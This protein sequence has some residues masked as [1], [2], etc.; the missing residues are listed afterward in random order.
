MNSYPLYIFR[1][2]WL[3][4]CVILLN[5]TGYPWIKHDFGVSHDTE[6]ATCDEI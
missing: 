5:F 4:S 1:D 3:V 6:K 2:T